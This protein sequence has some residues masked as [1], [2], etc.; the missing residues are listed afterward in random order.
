M[1]LTSCAAQ[2]LPKGPRLL[3]L[4]SRPLCDRDLEAWCGAALGALKDV[5]S[6]HLLPSWALRPARGLRD[7]GSCS[8]GQETAPTPGRE[9]GPQPMDSGENHVRFPVSGHRGEWAEGV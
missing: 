7:K 2:E 3:E 8:V 9:A 1:T 6:A 4:E 5:R